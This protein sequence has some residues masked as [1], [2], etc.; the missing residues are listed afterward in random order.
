MPN[1]ITQRRL[2][3]VEKRKRVP[4]SLS[5]EQVTQGIS[6][7]GFTTVPDGI[8]TEEVEVSIDMD[9]LFQ[10]LGHKAIRNASGKSKAMNGIVTVKHIR[11]HHESDSRGTKC[12]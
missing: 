7:S 11:N 8:T 3:K 1:L 5:E 12:R 2:L 9:K 10:V 6:T 4:V